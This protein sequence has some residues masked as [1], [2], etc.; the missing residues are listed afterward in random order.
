M[1][2]HLHVDDTTPLAG[3]IRIDDSAQTTAFQGWLD[4]LRLLSNILPQASDAAGRSEP[5]PRTR[6]ESG[7]ATID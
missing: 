1:D 5:L 6:G 7:G 3:S 4:L 2:V